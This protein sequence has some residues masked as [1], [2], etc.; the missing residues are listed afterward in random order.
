[1]RSIRILAWFIAAIA[2]CIAGTASASDAAPYH[3][4]FKKSRN[5]TLPSIAEEG[6]MD[7]LKRHDAIFLGGTR[8]KE[9]YLTFDNG[10]ENGLTSRILDVLRDKKVPAAFFVTG[11]FVKDQPELIVR[12]ALEGHLIGNHSWSHPDL[13][14]VGAGRIREEMEQVREA[15]AELTNRET[16]RY[17]RPPRGIFS[18][19]MLGACRELGYTGVFW[20]V[21]Y[22]DWDVNRQQ[23]WRYAFDN[24]MGQLHPG[25]VILLHSVSRDNAE[26]LDRIIDAARQQGYEFKSLDELTE[27]TYR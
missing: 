3:F 19:A 11:H 8:K 22:K 17:M 14:Q 21:A 20:S 13:S 15:V 7:V 24:V 5:G 9:L 12:M 2:L 23:G 25:A 27:K 16:M 4:G 26:A 6:F 18:G 1:M 10:Y